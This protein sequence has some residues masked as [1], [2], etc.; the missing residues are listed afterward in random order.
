MCMVWCGVLCGVVSCRVVCVCG[1]FAQEQKHVLLDAIHVS[2]SVP[3]PGS[4]EDEVVGD[5]VGKQH[6]CVTKVW[7]TVGV[8]AQPTVAVFILFILNLLR[9]EY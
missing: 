4:N 5:V 2:R 6:T 9:K 1:V 3:R 8:T 7:S